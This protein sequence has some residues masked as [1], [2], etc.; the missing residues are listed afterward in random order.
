MK[1]TTTAQVSVDGVMQGPGGPEENRSG[2]FE[3][4][5][6][7]MPHFDDEGE[8]AMEEIFQ[9]ADAFLFG[10]RTYEIFAGSW[11]TGTWGADQGDNPI[12][13]ALNTR[14]KYVAS[15]TLTDPQW[16]DTA[17]ISGDVAAAVA[18]LKA[19]PGRELQ[20]HGNGALFRWLLDNDLVDEMN[21]LIIPVVLGQGTRLFPDAGPDIA[22]Q[23]VDSRADSKGVTIQVYRPTGRPRYASAGAE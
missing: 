7:A 20:V 2:G 1:L 19:K 12:S 14:P 13:A 23:L 6:W 22:L 4:G 11:G 21:L 8:T 18:E 15:T 17:V 3:R 16:A 5:G 10:R 9:R